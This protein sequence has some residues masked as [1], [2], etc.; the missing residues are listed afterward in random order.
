MH[1]QLSEATVTIMKFKNKEKYPLELWSSY[2]TVLFQSKP[3]FNKWGPRCENCPFW[4]A[5][6][7]WEVVAGQVVSKGTDG[8]SHSGTSPRRPRSCLPKDLWL[9]AAGAGRR[10]LALSGYLLVQ[11]SSCKG[12]RCI[13]PTRSKPRNVRVTGNPGRIV[14]S[15]ICMY[16]G[17]C[18]FSLGK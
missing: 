5:G 3:V 6:L 17:S 18:Y 12:S 16:S 10:W 8:W 7:L 2:K 4:I 13:T 15:G 11:G 1:G 14:F 9:Q